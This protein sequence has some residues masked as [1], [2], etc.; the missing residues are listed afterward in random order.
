MLGML[1]EIEVRLLCYVVCLR[2]VLLVERFLGW[3]LGGLGYIN[4]GRNV[5]YFFFMLYKIFIFEFI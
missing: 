2:I 4:N 5:M 3:G 1:K